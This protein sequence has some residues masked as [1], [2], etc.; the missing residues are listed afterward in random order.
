MASALSRGWISG[1]Y[2]GNELPRCLHKEGGEIASQLRV[3]LVVHGVRGCPKVD[4]PSRS[5]V[6]LSSSS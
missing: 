1:L 5:D 6:T 3:K 2:G 4:T